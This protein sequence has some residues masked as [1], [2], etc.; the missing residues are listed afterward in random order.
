MEIAGLNEL[1]SFRH[2]LNLSVVGFF[3]RSLDLGLDHLE[4]F[5]L[6]SN[7]NLIFILWMIMMFGYAAYFFYFIIF[8][9]LRT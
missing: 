6:N 8:T 1:M 7:D 4:Y 2:C 9:N 3:A 5:S